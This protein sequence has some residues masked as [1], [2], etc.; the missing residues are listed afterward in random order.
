MDWSSDGC[1]SDRVRSRTDLLTTRASEA[2]V[3]GY[4]SERCTAVENASSAMTYLAPVW[5]PAHR[6]RGTRAAGRVAEPVS[7]S[8]HARI[9]PPRPPAG[10]G[11]CRDRKSGV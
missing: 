4:A 2:I 5:T 11:G 3:E 6:G 9:I 8:V 10:Q 1:S 7:E